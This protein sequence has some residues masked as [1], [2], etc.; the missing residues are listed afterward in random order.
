MPVNTR[1]AGGGTTRDPGQQWRSGGA[2]GLLD[3]AW[4]EAAPGMFKHLRC[5]MAPREPDGASSD[6][7]EPRASKRASKFSAPEE[8][9]AVPVLVSPLDRPPA[10]TEAVQPMLQPLGG[11]SAPEQPL[12]GPPI[13]PPPPP[14]AAEPAT[15]THAKAVEESGCANHQ[16]CPPPFPGDEI[17]AGR[18]QCQCRPLADW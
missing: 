6:R 8:L 1:A 10:E 9:A 14:P 12:A 7:P 2:R 3:Q 17:A 16:P 18:S 4:R 5:C 11:P 15:G 13:G